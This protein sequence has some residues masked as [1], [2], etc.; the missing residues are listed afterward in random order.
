M[1][2]STLF[3]TGSPYGNIAKCYLQSDPSKQSSKSAV[4]Q[5]VVSAKMLRIK[6]LQN[7]LADAHYHLNV[8]S[9]QSFKYVFFVTFIEKIT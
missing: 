2:C 5:R 3:F 9:G 7:Q 6:E 4:G 8:R 1:F